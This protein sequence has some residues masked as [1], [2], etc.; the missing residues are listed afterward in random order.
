MERECVSEPESGTSPD[1]NYASMLRNLRAFYETHA[2]HPVSFRAEQLRTLGRAIESRENDLLD[3]LYA[4]VR[5]PPLE[6]YVSGTRP[7]WL[8]TSSPR[9]IRMEN[10]TKRS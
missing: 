6:A 1:S 10:R 7:R 2:T 8:Q 9:T 5:K 3:A 4:D